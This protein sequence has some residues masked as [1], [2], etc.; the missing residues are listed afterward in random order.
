MTTESLA[1]HR[2]TFNYDNFDQYYES[3]KKDRSIRTKFR[4]WRQSFHC[5]GSSLLDF[6]TNRLPV[7]RWLPKYKKDYLFGDIIA[8]ATVGVVRVPQGMAYALLASV[9][10]VYGLYSCFFPVILWFFFSTSK[11]TSVGTNGVICLMLSNLIGKYFNDPGII[12]VTSSTNITV[13]GVQQNVSALPS[14]Y[15]ISGSNGT[16]FNT[17]LSDQFK[18]EL[19]NDYEN[20]AVALVMSASL[21][22]GI[23]QLVMFSFR[24]GFLTTLLPDPVIQGFTT[25]ASF[26]V[27]MSQAKYLFGLSKIVKREPGICELFYT[28]GKIIKNMNQTN[29]IDLVISLIALPTLLLFKH[30]NQKYK[31]KLRNIPIPVEFFLIIIATTLSHLLEWGKK[32]TDVAIVD[33]VPLGFVY[34]FKVPKYMDKTGEIF[35]DCVV[36]ALISVAVSLSLTKIYADKHD[37]DTDANQ[38]IFSLGFSNTIAS[39]I[40]SFAVAASLSRTAI[41]DSAGGKTQLVSVLSS[42]LMLCVLLFIGTLFEPVPKSVLACIIIAALKSFF[43]QFSLLPNLYRVCKTDFVVWIVTCSA[44]VIMGVDNGLFIGM[45]FAIA[46]LLYR[47]QHPKHGLLG[48][49]TNTDLYANVNKYPDATQLMLIKIFHFADSISYTNKDAFRKKLYQAVGLNPSKVLQNPS[50]FNRSKT[51]DSI[52][53]ETSLMPTRPRDESNLRNR[54]FSKSTTVN[55]GF[56]Y[57][58]IDATMWSFVDTTACKEIISI[59]ERF[60]KLNVTVMF[61]GMSPSILRTLDNM[62]LFE[63]GVKKGHMF[64]TLHDCVLTCE[65]LVRG[66][67]ANPETPDSMESRPGYPGFDSLAL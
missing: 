5:N 49:I 9:P 67:F 56:K 29:I 36:M 63:S 52:S 13:A 22:V 55:L 19:K 60:N 35:K 31:K 17:S 46:V 39:F 40:G 66:N 65:R 50:K 43:M 34:S 24:L 58:V 27:A 37:Y 4:Q 41:Q 28:L 3:K 8:A 38:E 42:T 18:A 6:V 44:V 20:D 7:L 53:E 59:V 21:I 48:R 57:L 23:I 14:K 62:K 61:A 32:G 64:I 16:Y 10:P 26:H 12:K 30:I 25:G 47:L 1:V 33:S 45:F 15:I 54:N 2:P 11:H 51:L